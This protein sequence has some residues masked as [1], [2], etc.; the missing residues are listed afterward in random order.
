M[1]NNLG[2][3]QLPQRSKWMPNIL[4]KMQSSA[5]FSDCIFLLDFRAVHEQPLKFNC[6]IFQFAVYCVGRTKSALFPDHYSIYL[7]SMEVTMMLIMNFITIHS[8]SKCYILVTYWS[9]TQNQ[10]FLYHVFSSSRQLFDEDERAFEEEEN[11]NNRTIMEDG[12]L[13]QSGNGS[14][15][16]PPV[17]PLR[18]HNSTEAILTS[19]TSLPSPKTSSS[20]QHSES[21]SLKNVKFSV[22]T[23]FTKIF[24][25]MIS[26]KKAMQWQHF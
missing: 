17:L 26:R 8:K 6:A 15:I 20:A 21:N 18:N 23:N 7:T 11:S 25:K 13:E 2:T 19:M 5:I 14:R 24:V 9:G 16:L 4:K 3:V 1:C 10:N 22:K 12:E